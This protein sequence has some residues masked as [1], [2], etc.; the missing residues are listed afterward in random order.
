[1]TAGLPLAS[2]T[3]RR[4]STEFD[5][6]ADVGQAHR[7][8]VAIG[9]DQRT[10]VCGLVGLVVGID[11]VALAL[12]VDAALRAVGVGAAECRAD[13]FQPNAV[14]VERRRQQLDA[15]GGQRAAA[16][17]DFA[18]AFDLRQLLGQHGRGGVIEFG[19]HQRVRG[20]G[21]DQ[22]R[23]R[24]GIELAVG[25]IASQ[26]RRQVG[27]RRIDGGLHVACGAVDVAADVELQIDAG[28]AQ[29]ARRRHF[30][31]IGDLAEVTLEWA[32]D[33]RRHVHRARARQ[34]R[35]HRNGRDIDVRQRRDRQL[36]KRD[37][38]RHHKPKRQ[39]RGSDRTADKRRGEIHKDA[40]E[41]VADQLLSGNASIKKVTNVT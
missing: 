10:V 3:V 12:D 26:A 13:V 35:L 9:D 28:R 7:R 11:L 37:R 16:D 2:P 41:A 15:H 4:F 36:E 33:R 25:R 38:A 22:D 17:G 14:F 39:Q 23:R 8:A 27:A 19:R 40:I 34:G 31:D 32:R 24:G 20:Q 30:R 5:D 29:R 6:V 1:M 18:D 21:V